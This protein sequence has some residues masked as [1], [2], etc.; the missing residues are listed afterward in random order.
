M[1]VAEQYQSGFCVRP[2]LCGPMQN[3]FSPAYL[4]KALSYEQY[5]NMVEAYAGSGKTTGAEQ[6]EELIQ[7]TKLNFSR[8]QRLQKT[9]E[10]LPDVKTALQQV[11]QGQRW[12]VLSESWCGDAAQSLPVISALAD[13][14]PLIQLHV[15]LRDENPGLMNQYLTNGSKSI[16]KLIVFDAANGE[17]LFNWG[18]RPLPAQ[19]LV[20]DLMEK[21]LD[22]SARGLEVQKWYNQ[23][24]GISLQKEIV[25]LLQAKQILA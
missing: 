21:G 2:Y 12:L 4:S 14:N 23:D 13:Q 15:L 7:Y 10:L 19:N 25:A 18:P 17:E 24:K 5:L 9:I 8:M 20:K 22:K 6:S 16:P 11:S 3:V 1:S